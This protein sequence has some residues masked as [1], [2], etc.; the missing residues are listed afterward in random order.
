MQHE[1]VESSHIS[2]HVPNVSFTHSELISIA[3]EATK[4][5]HL[6]DKYHSFE[7]QL[8]NSI[9][10]SIRN[11]LAVTVT[12]IPCSIRLSQV[13]CSV[14]KA[15]TQSTWDFVQLALFPKAVLRV[16][17][18]HSPFR[19][20]VPKS[21]L[22]SHLKTWQSQGGIVQLWKEIEEL[23]APPPISSS[24]PSIS[25]T[26]ALHWARLGGLGNDIKALSSSGVAN[27]EDSAVQAEILRCHHEGPVPIFLTCI[28]VTMQ[29]IFWALKVF[30]KG[31]SPGGFQLWSQHLLDAVSGFTAPV[32]Q[33]CLHHL[34]CLINFLFV[35]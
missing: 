30:H 3:I 11:I 2:S 19:R 7:S 9:L 23:S 8:V 15:A 20:E 32:A 4:T 35:R 16:P 25:T 33:E 13:L 10:N 28:T 18:H 17:A 21:L 22:K 31:F 26:R 5:L 6:S 34:T 29:S 24:V 27:P 12:H 1:A 14:L